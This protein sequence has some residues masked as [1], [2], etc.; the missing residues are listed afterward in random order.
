MGI[1]MDFAIDINTVGNVVY[2]ND[3]SSY[4]LFFFNYFFFIV[5]PLVYIE[6]IVPSVFADGYSKRILC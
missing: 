1:R 3:T 4:F 6:G 5:I 2:I